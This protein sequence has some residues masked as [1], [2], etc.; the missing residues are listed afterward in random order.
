V[1]HVWAEAMSELQIIETALEGAARRRR[2]A[3]AMRAMW[4]GLLVG[5]I[6]SLVLAG[7]YHLW[8]LP[9]WTRYAVAL[10]PLPCALAGLIQGGWRKPALKDV[11]RWVDSRRRLKERLST[12]LE[13]SADPN[14]GA[15]RD[16]VVADAAAHARDLDA[17]KLVPFNLP[18]GATRWALVVLALG[19]GLGFVP[20]YR[21]QRFLQ[22]E[23]EQQAIKDAG[24]QLSELTR[25]NLDKRTPALESTQKALET[26]N[27]LG[28]KLAKASLTRSDALKDLA[29]VAEKLKDELK[30]LS[31]DP[32][33]KRMEQA[34]RA[35][36]GNESQTAAGLQ[37]QIESLQ[38][39]MGTPLGKPDDL[40][41][42]KKELQKLEA[43]A[44]GMNDKSAAGTEAQKQELSQALSALSHQAQEMGLQLPGLDEAMK[45]L[46]D[47]KTEL[48]LKDLEASLTDLEKM[49]DMAK[50]L[51]Q[52]QQQAEKLGKDL[53]EQLKNG[54]PEAA[55]MTLQKM[56]QQLKSGNLA[57]E[58]LQKIL[59]EVTKA[60]E[61]AA[62]Y[63][64][65][66]EL[67]KAGSKQMQ[68]GDKRGASQ[69][70]A[71]AA[72]EL[73]KLTQ[74]MGDAQALMAELQALDKASLCVGNCQG[75][76][77]CNRPGL[78][79]KGGPGGGVGTW[80]DDDREWNGQWTDHWDNTGLAR[81]D[82][83]PRGHTDRGEG[84][85]SDALRPTKVKGQFSPGSQM[86]SITLRNVSIKGQSRIDYEEAST[87]AQSDAQSALSH[88][89]VPRAYQGAVKDYFDDLKK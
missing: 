29:N 70:L 77:Q 37:K 31:K 24:R 53:A 16:L 26:V 35:S 72:K 38:K 39:Q 44:K 27:E 54:Q 10:I 19:S 58:Q 52:L 8:P 20:E 43:A 62:N 30:D 71:E 7:V 59:G 12:A 34:A 40:D 11:A 25:R 69:S 67:L 61:P 88:E 55:Q 47:S 15:W 42:V 1:L 48:F 79:G 4:V 46:A 17:R 6:L 28:D 73:E 18:R 75:W 86:P 64:Q 33:F 80:G 23:N 9:L 2:W 89:Q 74:Q 32:M 85:L 50:T 68:A 22:R 56:A 60:I 3:M 57:P 45:A 51:Q 83:D 36:A 21:S 82:V 87:A 14:G 65:V 63:G 66:A 13:V 49:K 76:R 81:P 41:K 84:D 78:G 5:A